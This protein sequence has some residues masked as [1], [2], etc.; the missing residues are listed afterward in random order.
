MS[1][2]E[3]KYAV[4]GQHGD[5]YSLTAKQL[6]EQISNN[7]KLDYNL[8]ASASE[9]L[10]ICKKPSFPAEYELAIKC[11]ILNCFA[12]IEHRANC[13]GD[14]YIVM[15]A[16]QEAVQECYNSLYG[17]KNEEAISARKRYLT[18]IFATASYIRIFDSHYHPGPK[19]SKLREKW[20]KSKVQE[21]I[22]QEKIDFKHLVEISHKEFVEIV[23][24]AEIYGAFDEDKKAEIESW[25]N[26]YKILNNM[27][28]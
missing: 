18:E 12:N 24:K 23:K 7:S 5:I 14:R 3:K 20:I 25:K 11:A 27:D 9:L 19:F 2:V 17:V 15:P 6:Y 16:D 8:I 22:S 4:K 21:Y 13:G 26:F 10:K 1:L 28:V